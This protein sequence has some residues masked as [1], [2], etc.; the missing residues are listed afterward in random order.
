MSPATVLQLEKRLLRRFQNDSLIHLPPNFVPGVN[1]ALG[2]WALMQHHGAPTRLL[3]W[4]ESIYVAAYFACC[5]AEQEDGAIWLFHPN[6]FV[7]CSGAS[8]TVLGQIDEASSWAF[9]E[10]TAESI[11]LPR[12]F[13]RFER[14]RTQQGFFTLPTKPYSR[15]DDL[16]LN[17]LKDSMGDRLAECCLKIIVP[18]ALKSPIL[19]NLHSMNITAD[20]LFPGIDGLGRTL[21]LLVELEMKYRNGQLG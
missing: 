5:A 16:I 6:K 10:S 17:A 15:I 14:L 19:A 18:G 7:Q 9:D 8:S 20:T 13:K 11:L 21:C 3:D 4:S 2:W 12:H 1:D